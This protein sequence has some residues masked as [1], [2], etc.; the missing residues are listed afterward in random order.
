MTSARYL[1]PFATCLANEADQRRVIITPLGKGWDISVDPPMTS[2]NR[3]FADRVGAILYS[4]GL[5]MELDADIVP[6]D[7]T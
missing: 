5:A 3:F 7:R 2:H 4:T 6:A 1:S